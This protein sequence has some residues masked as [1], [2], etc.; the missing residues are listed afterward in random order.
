MIGLDT[1][2]FEPVAEPIEN[3]F[4]VSAVVHGESAHE[5]SVSTGIRTSRSRA[6]RSA[7]IDSNESVLDCNTKSCASEPF[8]RIAQGRVGG[9]DGGEPFRR[10][11]GGNART[12]SR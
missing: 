3:G 9:V 4:D 10:R 1:C 7:S 5:S 6:F 8:G 2:V 12:S 11:S